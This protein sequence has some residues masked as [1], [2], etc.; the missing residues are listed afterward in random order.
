QHARVLALQKALGTRGKPVEGISNHLEVGSS[1]LGNDEALTLAPEQLDAEFGFQRLDLMAHRSL[2]HEQL[3]GGPG[4]ALVAGSGL[5]GFEGIKCWQ[6]PRHVT[7]DQF[8][9]KTKAG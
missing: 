7:R 6:S 1:G 3:V 2:G 9:R 5:E 4:E 8:M